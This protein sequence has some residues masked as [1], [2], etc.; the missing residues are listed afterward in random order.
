V[1]KTSFLGKILAIDWGEKSVGFAV[2]DEGQNMTFGRGVMKGSTLPKIFLFVLELVK[3][4]KIVKIIVGLPLSQDGEDTAQTQKIRRIMDELSQYLRESQ[5][6]VQVPLE[7]VDESFSS[8]QAQKILLEV[9]IPSLKHKQTED[10]MAA[11]VILQRYI[12][13]SS[14]FQYNKSA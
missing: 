12:D 8:H 10:E 14:E 1:N 4:E 7:F 13:F 11:I 6:Q 3:L 5:F 9:G 2:C